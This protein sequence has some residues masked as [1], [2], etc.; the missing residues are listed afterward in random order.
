ML[1]PRPVRR[2]AFLLVPPTDSASSEP[3]VILVPR[4]LLRPRSVLAPLPGL[5][6]RLVTLSSSLLVS[7]LLF[8]ARS[9][10]LPSRRRDGFLLP[11]DLEDP[12]MDRLSSSFSRLPKPSR[13][14]LALTS[15]PPPFLCLLVASLS[16]GCFLILDP[17]KT[18]LTTAPAAPLGVCD[19]KNCC[20]LLWWFMCS[21][22]S[23][24]ELLAFA[25]S[26]SAAL[27]L[28]FSFSLLSFFSLLFCPSRDLGLSR[29]RGLSRERGLS[30]DRG[31]FL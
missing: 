20:G 5:L 18:F 28:S 10:L 19:V 24:C 16:T 12:P 23:S 4:S 27:L 29:D 14:G 17:P 30:R 11:I 7:L 21:P 1:L 3:S 15:L 9:T 2:P 13:V 25:D 6:P 31:F 8:L 26:C 22:F